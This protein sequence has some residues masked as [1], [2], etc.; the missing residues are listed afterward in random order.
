MSFSIIA[1]VGKNGEIGANGKL[2]WPNIP[3][4]MRNFREKT[5][6][7]TVIMG[8]KTFESIGRPLPDRTNIVV[9]R[10]KNYQAPGCVTVHSVEQALMKTITEDETFIIGGAEIYSNAMQYVDK[11]YLTMVDGKFTADTFFPHID[12]SE[13]KITNTTTGHKKEGEPLGF[14]FIEYERIKKHD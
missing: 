14:S 10:D 2:P 12:L 7:H 5:R 8:R 9:S 6:G 3:D 13:W 1:A 4:D 11:M